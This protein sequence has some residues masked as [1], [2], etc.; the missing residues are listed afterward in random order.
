ML[1]KTRNALKSMVS[2]LLDVDTTEYPKEQVALLNELFRS[3][4]NDSA[5]REVHELVHKLKKKHLVTEISVS[6]PDGSLV[7]STHLEG[8]KDAVSGA[9]LYHYIN[10]EVPKA[11]VVT[12]ASEKNWNMFFP[13]NGRI[14]IVQAPSSLEPVELRA[15]AHDIEEFVTEH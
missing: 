7:A 3:N 13:Y 15:I 9:A 8:E 1:A 14:Y 11:R 2:R 5:P 6:R 4:G 12:V 10:S